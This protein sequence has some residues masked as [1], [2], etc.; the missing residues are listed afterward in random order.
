[1]PVVWGADDDHINILVFKHFA[2]VLVLGRPRATQF[3][4]IFSTLIQHTLVYI[5]ERHTIDLW[6]FEVRTHVGPTHP[7]TANYAV[8]DLVI[9]SNISGEFTKVGSSQKR[10]HAQA[11]AKQHGVLYKSSS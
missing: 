10:R 7:L 8:I 4:Y 11:C 5:A 3:E 6:D 2:V 9:G 1:M